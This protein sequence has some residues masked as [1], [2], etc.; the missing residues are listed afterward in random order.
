MRKNWVC[1]EHGIVEGFQEK[2][3]ESGIVRMFFECLV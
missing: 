2:F 1:E 3:K